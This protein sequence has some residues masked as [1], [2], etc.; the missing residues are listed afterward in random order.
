M[1]LSGSRDS[2]LKTW[3][4][5]THITT[6]PPAQQ[7][8]QPTELVA[9]SSFSDR[10]SYNCLDSWF[11][12]STRAGE[13]TWMCCLGDMDGSVS[14]LSLDSRAE[15]RGQGWDLVW[16]SAPYVAGEEYEES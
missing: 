4:L 11:E 5:D 14:V 13:G 8:Q 16:K 9:V 10:S 2:T 3:A 7:S 6:G 15:G 12:E 1:L